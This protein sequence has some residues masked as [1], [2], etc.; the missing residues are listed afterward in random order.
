M[1]SNEEIL[2]TLGLIQNHIIS[3][4]SSVEEVKMSKQ[5]AVEMNENDRNI[6]LKNISTFEQDLVNNIRDTIIQQQE[7]MKSYNDDYNE[8]LLSQNRRNRIDAENLFNRVENTAKNIRDLN[9]TVRDSVNEGLEKL[10]LREEIKTIM[11]SSIKSSLENQ[12]KANEQAVIKLG[13]T[14]VQM[15]ETFRN[16]VYAPFG[17]IGM[18]L[19]VLAFF[20]GFRTHEIYQNRI[21]ENVFEL[22]YSDRFNEEL[23]EPLKEAKIEASEYL[24]EQKIEANDYKKLKEQE[25]DDYLKNKIIEADEEYTRR[26]QAYIENAKNEVSKSMKKNSKKGD[27]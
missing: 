3:I 23:S 7:E 4:E 13:N 26:L 10:H 24:K 9:T 12:T 27:N 15:R 11:N 25:A 2:D 20:A 22:F 17:F 8:Q 19:I 6:L 14:A 16:N 5:E 21:C 18:V 1:A